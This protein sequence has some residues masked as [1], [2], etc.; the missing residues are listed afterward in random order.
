LKEKNL[1]Q[2]L[3]EQYL[4]KKAPRK[5]KVIAATQYTAPDEDKVSVAIIQ[6]RE[7]DFKIGLAKDPDGVKKGKY[8]KWIKPEDG[9]FFIK[10]GYIK[11]K[12]SDFL[13]LFRRA[14]TK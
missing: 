7:G 4:Q 14:K 9:P 3:P 8:I 10:E 1:P 13:K 11:G 12:L 5:D 6:T 2:Y